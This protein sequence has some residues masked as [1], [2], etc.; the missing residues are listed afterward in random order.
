MANERPRAG[1]PGP[2]GGNL[3][4]KPGCR[5][6]LSSAPSWRVPLAQASLLAQAASLSGQRSRACGAWARESQA[7]SCGR[8]TSEAEHHDPR[9][10]RIGDWD[11]PESES[12][13]TW[14][15]RGVQL[16]DDST[17]PGQRVPSSWQY[18]THETQVA[19]RIQFFVTTRSRERS[20][21]HHAAP[22]AHVKVRRG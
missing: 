15:A 7:G 21:N 1:L 14:T 12:A 6:S 3:G 8:P 19:A 11:S 20:K 10:T 18:S 5:A 2:F 17:Q 4:W 9:S 16:A 22:P 13:S